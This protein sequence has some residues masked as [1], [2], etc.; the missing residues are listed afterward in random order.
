VPDRKSIVAGID[1]GSHACRAMALA[2]DRSSLRFLG[3]AQMPAAGWRRGRI[4]DPPAVTETIRR[5]IQEL[6]AGIGLAI[7]SA[8]VGVGGP[9]V[10]GANCGG[11]CE[12]WPPRAVVQHDVS[13]AVE[14]SCMGP[15]FR[16]DQ[17]IMQ[18]FTQ[19]FL[20]NQD[21]EYRDPRGIQARLLE[22]NVH[23]ILASK[24]EHETIVGLCNQAQVSVEETVFE[25]VAAALAAVMPDDRKDNV[26]LIDI[27]QQSTELVI[28]WKD[29]LVHSASIPVGADHFTQ[30]VARGLH[31]TTTDAETMKLEY[32]CALVGLTAD[33]SRI[34][35]PPA[36]GGE[37]RESSRRRL[38]HILEARGREL[39]RLVGEQIAHAGM[40]DLLGTGI[41][42][43]GGGARLP[44]LC[45]LAE[46]VLNCPARLGLPI[47][48]RDLPDRMND[49][50]WT[51][52][53][54][55]AM[56]SSRLRLR[57]NQQAES[58]GVL[59][60]LFG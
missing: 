58:E 49:V 15:Q 2:V 10:R 45:D 4:T 38:N 48:I 31:V 20:V 55:L 30:D 35:L 60:K 14:R 11:Q 16:D 19:I 21:Q 8:V 29:M 1:I 44:G 18:I 13:R 36:N 7:E 17:M 52:T 23:V 27:G 9:V 57:Q 32:G 51:A 42:L 24:S 6:E 53:A 37:R 59:V 34:E 33:N 46:Q 56:Y 39:F 50:S 28:Y 41:V 25:P 5:T 12:I 40:N 22:A 54:G 3:A 26:A 47:G 43:A